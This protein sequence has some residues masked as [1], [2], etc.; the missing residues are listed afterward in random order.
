MS[1]TS[2][3][4]LRA[5]LTG[6][7]P[8][9]ETA[10]F[11][12]GDAGFEVVLRRLDKAALEKLVRESQRAGSANRNGRRA[13]R[14][15]VLAEQNLRRFRDNLCDAVLKTW[16]GL[17]TA[18]VCLM[19]NMEQPAG[20]P[21]PVRCTPENARI[22]CAHARANVDGEPMAF[23]DWLLREA[24]RISDELATAEADSKND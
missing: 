6:V 20:E 1:E 2:D 9:V 3:V 14:E 19:C 7:E 21:Q 18:K 23:E 10:T 22:L 16:E 11:G 17:D 12:D 4:D 15:D 24:T 5:F 13:V 8:L